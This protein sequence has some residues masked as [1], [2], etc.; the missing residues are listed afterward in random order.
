MAEV[1]PLVLDVDGTLLK[2]DLLFESFWAGL[3]QKPIETLKIVTRSFGNLAELKRE[4]ADLVDMRLDLMPTNPDILRLAQENTANGREVIL[5]SASDQALVRDLATHYDLSKEVLASDGTVNL[6]SE[7]KAAALVERFGVRGFDYAGNSRDDFAVWT[8]AENAIVVGKAAGAEAKLSAKGQNVTAVSG[9]WRKRDLIRA[10]RPHQWVKNVLLFLPMLAAHQFNLST[11]FAVIWGMVAFSAAASCIYIVN[12]LLDLEADR[13]HATKHKR[14]FASGAVPIRVGMAACLACGLVAVGVA[15]SLNLSFLAII[16]LYMLTSL[17]YS[18]RWKRMR[19][20]DIATLASLY[21]VRVV[22]GAAA[23]SVY[24]SGYMLVFVFPIFI[25]L[26]C[27][28]RLTELTLATSDDALPGRGYARRDRGDLLN[29]A[30]IGMVGALVTFLLYSFT[31]QAIELYPTRWMLWAAMVPIGMWLLRMIRLGWFG[32]QDHDPIVF[33]LR[34]KRGLG[35]LFLILSM[36]WYAAGLWQEW[37][38][39]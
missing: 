25:S 28:K 12:D 26:G 35:L 15:I 21:T 3:G 4:L 30:W 2:T 1:K 39:F 16:I 38:G 33:A 36:M 10:L 5:A 37:F 17:T 18:L 34:D 8:E 11:L 7:R 19:W 32:K 24:V 23:T 31:P 13:L 27:V 20:I 14:P 29:F 9:G 22:G 6:K